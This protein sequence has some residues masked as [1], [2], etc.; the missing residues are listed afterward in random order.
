VLRLTTQE[1]AIRTTNLLLTELGLNNA[2]ARELQNIP[3]AKLVAAN[4]AVYKKLTMREPGMVENSPMVDGKIIPDHPWDPAA[5]KLSAHI[6][7]NS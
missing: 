7:L 6:D 5:P 2:Q 1:D 3:F 4:A